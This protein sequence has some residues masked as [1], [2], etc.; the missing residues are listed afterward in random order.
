MIK[1]LFLISLILILATSVVFAT[2]GV[3][4]FKIPS[5]YSGHDDAGEYFIPGAYD[6][7]T[8]IIIKVN[9]TN[10]YFTNSSSYEVWGG[11]ESNTFY[12][13]D[14]QKS[15]IGAIELIEVENQQFVVTSQYASTL[16]DQDFLKKAMDSIL[17]FNQLNNITPIAP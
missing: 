1:K 11:S 10:T 17:E 6:N 2:K 3:D 13:A 7:P 15:L 9:D 12:Y 16:R 5:D 4:D 14:K 8:F